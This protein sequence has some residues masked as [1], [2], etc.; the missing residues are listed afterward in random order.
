[1]SMYPWRKE[2]YWNWN[3]E[4][5]EFD[6]LNLKAAL[7]EYYKFHINKDFKG[8]EMTVGMMEQ[9]TS[10]SLPWKNIFSLKG[11]EYAVNLKNLNLSNNFIEDIKTIEK[12]VEL[13]EFKPYKQ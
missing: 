3:S 8:E 4:K 5:I 1:M 6:D 10:L 9:F 13:E 11:L 7:I 12:L 2:I